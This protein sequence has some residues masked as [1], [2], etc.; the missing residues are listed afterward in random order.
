MRVLLNSTPF[1]NN[2]MYAHIRISVR[3][4]IYPLVGLASNHTDNYN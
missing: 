3:T 4:E 2:A 1:H